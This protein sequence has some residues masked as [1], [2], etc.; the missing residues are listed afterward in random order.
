MLTGSHEISCR[1][2]FRTQSFH[3]TASQLR[4]KSGPVQDILR[5]KG[6]RPDPIPRHADG[7]D[8][9]D[10]PNSPEKEPQQ[11]QGHHPSEPLPVSEE[12]TR[13]EDSQSNNVSD[14]P[15]RHIL[16]Y[17]FQ[18][19]SRSF[20][21]LAMSLPQLHR[22][23]QE[24]FLRV[25][26][27]FWQR[28][29]IRF[30]W[31]TIKSF[32]KFNADDISGI[33]T[34]ILMSQTIWILVGTTTFLSVIFA[35]VN[36]LRLQHFV[37][38]G[39]SD[40]LTSETGITIIFES[41]IV[42]K[43]K[44]SRISF[45]N[46]YVSRRPMTTPRQKLINAHMAAAGIGIQEY[47]DFG[48]Y[49]EDEAHVV[50]E[51]DTNYSMFDLNIDSVDVTLSLWRWLDGRGLVEDAVVKGVRGVLD[52][53]S[54]LYDPEHPLDPASFRHES[55]VGDFELDSLQLED[56]LVTV[57]QPGG[58]RPYTAS[59]FRADIR[60]FR[61]RWMFYDFLSA[62][63]IV[64][65]FDNC[66]FSLHKPQSIGR[67]MG[68][69]LHD[70]DWARMSR[71][72]IDGV[73]IDHLQASTSM[74]GPVSWI[75][76]GKL[77]AVLDI[78]FPKDPDDALALNVILEEIAD[79]IS[80]TL[81]TSPALDPLRQRIPGQRE[82]AKPPLSAPDTEEFIASPN[83]EQS[84]EPKVVIELDL[85]FRDV[86]AAVPIFTSDL[87]YV[88][89]ALIRPIVAFMNANR[90]LVPIH[91]RVVK[92][93]NDFDGAWTMWETGLLD[94]IS[95]K[96]YDALAFHVT[97]ANIN[98]R[99]KTVSV[100][101]L[102]MTASAVLSALRN[103]VDPVS[104]RVREAYLKTLEERERYWFNVEL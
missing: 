21:Q 62:E 88:N 104:I 23:T 53:R 50:S 60:T 14:D 93:L 34:W 39:I 84:K 79:A 102:Q 58:F 64:G 74:E 31:F 4:K 15:Q 76:S 38:R 77:D 96:I 66:L 20:R 28:L 27:G 11:V 33:A 35:I 6:A 47:Q 19:Y 40:Y 83:L 72:R 51:Q 67:T 8:Q 26:D 98:R 29:R 48:E 2:L 103:L 32:R 41:A 81:S 71:I 30:K 10:R 80:N 59:I 57:Y 87:S 3:S 73:S 69:E 70:G 25:A 91:C 45:K 13:T 100:W 99:I 55:H 9:K 65:Q 12:Q 61:K 22:P 44:D 101:S 54:V 16:P 90:T 92:V 42:P 52:R 36:S 94:E 37:A 89:N 82:L 75:T 85:R 24:D 49:E 78:K 7:S 68:S 18:Y 86:K 17:N 43:W 63:N 46:V 95:L 1:S 56:V 97:Q 5:Q